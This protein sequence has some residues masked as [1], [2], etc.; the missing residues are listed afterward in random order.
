MG[1]WCLQTVA[2]NKVNHARIQKVLPERVQ[3]WQLW[4]GEEGSKYHYKR[5]IIGPPAKRQLNGIL[6][7]CRCWPNI[8]CWLGSLVIFQGIRT[9]IAKKPYIFVIFR[10][11]GGGGSGPPVPPLDPNL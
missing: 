9:S 5:A 8:E 3:I 6:L 1:V 2:T 7:A 11:G 10:G 4:W